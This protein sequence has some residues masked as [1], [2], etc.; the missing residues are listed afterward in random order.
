MKTRGWDADDKLLRKCKKAGYCPEK[1]ENSKQVQQNEI[2][3][4][5]KQKEEN[6]PVLAIGTFLS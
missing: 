1:H 2:Y 3:D 5:V 4:V 6:W